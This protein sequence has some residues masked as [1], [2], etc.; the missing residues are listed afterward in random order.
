MFLNQDLLEIDIEKMT[1]PSLEQIAELFEFLDSDHNGMIEASSIITL[2]T[3]SEKLKNA[4]FDLATYAK[5]SQDV[6]P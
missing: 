6:S 5:Q 2:I 1:P 4:N 3:E